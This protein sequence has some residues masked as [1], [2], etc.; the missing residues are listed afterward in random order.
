METDIEDLFVSVVIPTYHDWD[1]LKLCLNALAR[2]TYPENKFEIIVV[3]NDPEDAPPEL[4][5]KCLLINE[6]KPGS[7]AARNTGIGLAK[8]DVIAFT[9]SDCIPD[10]DWLA[11]AIAQLKE[12]NVERVAGHVEIF[13]SNE[14]A[15]ATE[16][17]EKVVAF[18]QKNNVRNGVSVTANLIVYRREFFNIGFFNEN[19]MSGG[20]FEWNHKATQAG[21]SIAYGEKCIV[22][23]PARSSL[24]ELKRKIKRVTCSTVAYNKRPKF[25]LLRAFAPPINDFLNIWK[26][27]GMNVKE[28]ALASYI[29]YHIK[30]YRCFVRVKFQLGLEKSSRV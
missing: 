23:H 1:R 12:S 2:Q 8:G 5:E 14:K 24:R 7:Y 13:F 10:K 20:D 6:H 4:L 16:L 15:N 9:D 22:L 29:A 18:D 30:L 17:Y 11:R 3:N 27:N 25:F 28:K 26:K 19:L 21:L